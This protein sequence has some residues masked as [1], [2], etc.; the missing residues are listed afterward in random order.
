MNEELSARRP[1]AD[2][3]AV[4]F[5]IV[6]PSV[7]TWVYFV[8]LKDN[9]AF[10]QQTAY[11]IGKAL[12]FAFPVFWV[13]LIQRQRIEIRRP[14]R[15]GLGWGLVTGLAIVAGMFLLYHVFLKPGGHFEAA[16]NP[17]REKVS[18][19]GLDRLWKYA[20]LGLFYALG[21]SFLEE[22]YWRWFVF[23]QL[24]RLTPVWVAVI[25]SSVGFMAHHVILLSAFFGWGT[26]ASLFFSFSV[27][28][29]GVIWACLYH[30]TGSLYGPWLSH[31][32]VDA[33]IFLVGY[34]VVWDMFA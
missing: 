28:V 9:A 31:A 3:T 24:R 25:V 4:V 7:V 29:G 19:F 13:L 12:Q 21:H 8:L 14:G 34:D 11:S 33:G 17:I 2:W 27:C 15:Q 10:V 30:R 22:Y 6:F 26:F 32:L 23:G 18:G 16:V 5:A 1:A 20:G